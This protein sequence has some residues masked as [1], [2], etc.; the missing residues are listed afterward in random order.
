MYVYVALSFIGLIYFLELAFLWMFFSTVV[1]IQ[2]RRNWYSQYIRP[3]PYWFSSKFLLC[4]RNISV[5]SASKRVCKWQKDGN[6]WLFSI[7]LMLV[8]CPT[9]LCGIVFRNA[10]LERRKLTVSPFKD[11]GLWNG[12]GCTTTGHWFFIVGCTGSKLLLIYGLVIWHS[13]H[14][15]TCW[16]DLSSWSHAYTN[17]P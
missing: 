16:I 4:M 6:A 5:E 11:H 14:F 10:H 15:M 17:R 8:K 1:V 7:Y 9:N 13:I 2:G 3:S 12:S